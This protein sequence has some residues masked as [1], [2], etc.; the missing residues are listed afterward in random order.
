MYDLVVSL[1]RTFVPIAVGGA[2]S[3]LATIG[4]AGVDS[5]EAVAV[6]T[7]LTIGAYYA[8]VRG[9]EAK[10]PVAGVL[11]GHKTAP[12]YTET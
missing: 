3:A 8:I 1:I 7:S 12:A 4:V 6:V 10:Y 11:L 2:L 9:V 5:A